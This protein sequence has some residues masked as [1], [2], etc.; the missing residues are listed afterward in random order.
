[1]ESP[2]LRADLRSVESRCPSAWV[3]KARSS[4][5]PSAHLLQHRRLKT[6]PV[7][8]L[9]RVPSGTCSHGGVSECSPYLI[10]WHSSGRRGQ[11]PTWHIPPSWSRVFASCPSPEHL[12]S[13]GARPGTALLP[14]PAQEQHGGQGTKDK[15]KRGMDVFPKS[16]P[17]SLCHQRNNPEN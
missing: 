14:A 6:P 16:C 11:Q 5:L 8:N 15:D 9:R 10:Q 2:G 1:M 4:R 13:A 7:K 17:W 3:Q 12:S